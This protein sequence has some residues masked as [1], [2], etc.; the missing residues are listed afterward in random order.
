MRCQFCNKELEKDEIAL[1]KKL[2]GKDIKG[3]MCIDCF[4]DYLNCTV[5][6][7]RVKVEEFRE[8]GCT[9]FK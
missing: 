9:L 1:C 5:D 7:L 6:D 4:A 2:L 8:H 3:F